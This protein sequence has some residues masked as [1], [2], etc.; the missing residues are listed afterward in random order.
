MEF[1]GVVLGASVLVVGM[2]LRSFGNSAVQGI[3][4][5]YGK[6]FHEVLFYQHALGLPLLLL[7]VQA[8]WLQCQA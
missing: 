1:A 2:L 6:H 7:N 3:Y 5:E 4:D 8:L